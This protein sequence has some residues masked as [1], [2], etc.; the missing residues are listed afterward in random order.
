MS[1]LLISFVGVMLVPLFVASWRLSCLG[2]AVQGLLMAWISYQLDPTMGSAASWV[3]MFDLLVVRGLA[4]QATEFAA[5]LVEA[6]QA[7]DRRDAREA[8]VDRRVGRRR[9]EAAHAD[10]HQRAEPGLGTLHPA[11]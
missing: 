2:L 8:A 9:V 7:M 1:P 11:V 4:V 3:R 5:G 10:A 6:H